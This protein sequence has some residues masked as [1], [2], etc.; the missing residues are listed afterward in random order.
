V[1]E[2]LDAGVELG[3]DRVVAFLTSELVERFEV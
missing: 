2:L 3:L 1:C